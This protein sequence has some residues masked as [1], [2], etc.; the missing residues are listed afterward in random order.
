MIGQAF[1]GLEIIGYDNLLKRYVFSW[2]STMGTGTFIMEGIADAD[3][4]TI[5]LKG[6][7]AEPGGGRMRPSRSLDDCQ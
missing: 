7:H 1:S 6:K 2:M 3:G 5:T 4:K